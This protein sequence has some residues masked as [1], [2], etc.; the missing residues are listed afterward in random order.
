MLRLTAFLYIIIDDRCADRASRLSFV[1]DML[2]EITESIRA[3]TTVQ[4][5]CSLI[6]SLETTKDEEHVSKLSLNTTWPFVVFTKYRGKRSWRQF[7][8]PNS[9]TVRFTRIRGYFTLA[10]EEFDLESNV[11]CLDKIFN[12]ILKSLQKFDVKRVQ[13]SNRRDAERN[14]AKF[15]Y[16]FTFPFFLLVYLLTIRWT[17]FCFSR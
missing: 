14:L 11:S 9:E 10:S 1:L 8:T 15:L 12:R 6:C 17:C 5:T 13:I 4:E 7:M 2:I 16:L 3:R